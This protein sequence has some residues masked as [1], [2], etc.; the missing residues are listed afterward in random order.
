M[1]RA[2]V[3]NLLDLVSETSEKLKTRS[4]AK[5]LIIQGGVTI[6]GDRAD[7]INM[8]VPERG[9]LQLKIGKKEFVIVKFK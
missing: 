2:S 9:E 6:D 3:G 7:D 1:D 4:E 8:P 5:R